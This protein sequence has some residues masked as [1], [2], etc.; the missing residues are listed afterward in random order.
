MMWFGTAA[1]LRK[2]PT[3]SGSICAGAEVVEPVSVVRDLGV[4]IDAELSMRDHISRTTRACYS[5]L[6][7]LRSIRTLLGRDVTVQLVMR[8]G[9]VAV[10]LLQ[11]YLRG[12]PSCD[13]RD[14]SASSSFSSPSHIRSEA[15]RSRDSSPKRSALAPNKGT[16]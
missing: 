11:R 5:H 10:E 2:R 4:W 7:R 1:S 6:R 8:S 13:P 12:S 3:G 15:I 14:S 16:R 9:T